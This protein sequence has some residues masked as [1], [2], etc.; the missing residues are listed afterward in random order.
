MVARINFNEVERMV[1]SLGSPSVQ[2]CRK[3]QC[4]KVHSFYM[5]QSTKLLETLGFQ[6][7]PGDKFAQLPVGRA[8]AKATKPNSPYLKELERVVILSCTSKCCDV[9]CPTARRFYEEQ[10]IL[11]LEI[12]GFQFMPGDKVAQLSVGLVWARGVVLG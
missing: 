7:K 9:S 10:S 8:W 12:L 11:L 4:L 5:E 2:I 1:K 6:F 3:T